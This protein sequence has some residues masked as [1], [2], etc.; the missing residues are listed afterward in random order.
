MPQLEELDIRHQATQ[1]AI[2][3]LPLII[4]LAL[5]AASYILIQALFPSG[6][7]VDLSLSLLLPAAFLLPVLVG[8]IMAYG[9]SRLRRAI[10]GQKDN[11]GLQEYLSQ[12]FTPRQAMGIVL[13][14]IWWPVYVQYFDAIKAH[15]PIIIPF[16]LD[17]L[18]VQADYLLHAGKHPFQLLHSVVGGESTTILIDRIY[19]SWYSVVILYLLWQAW[20]PDRR[21]RFRFLVC[22]A[23]IWFLFGNLLAIAA[24]SA[25]PL[26]YSKLY[27]PTSQ[28]GIYSSLTRHLQT[29]DASHP[30]YVWDIQKTLWSNYLRQNIGS[31]GSI[32]AMPSVHVAIATL[33]ALRAQ[34]SNKLFGGVAWGYAIL[35]LIG[36]V[37]LGWHYA[38]D[39]YVSVVLTVLLWLWSDSFT[40]WY[41]DKTTVRLDVNY[42][43]KSCGRIATR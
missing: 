1:A 13:V 15:I 24:S 31:V 10:T 35:T 4:L 40:D 39:G 32:S 21:L 38:I 6:P 8:C 9:A 26:F 2:E 17:P 7:S 16:Y 3:H 18:Y 33:L 28:S 43:Q 20:S 34:A 5:I 30:L 12:F 11:R 42:R 36:S 41:S 14:L 19:F 22:F 27:E 37:Y 23:L 25:G 29:V